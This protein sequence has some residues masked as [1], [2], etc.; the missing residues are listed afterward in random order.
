M[1]IFVFLFGLCMGSFVFAFYERFCE[2]KP[3]LQA[4]SFCFKCEKRLKIYHLIPLFSYIFL[5]GRCGFCGAK[6][7]PLSFFCEL[8]CGLLFIFAFFVTLSAEFN[9]LSPEFTPF[10]S[11][12]NVN[13]LTLNFVFLALFLSTLLLLSLI[14]LKLKAVPETLLWA[15]FILAFCYNPCYHIYAR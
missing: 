4:H 11:L 6:I 14:D 1:I 13:N 15:A 8:L 10:F 12:L 9:A 2:R 3:I 5:R 7:S